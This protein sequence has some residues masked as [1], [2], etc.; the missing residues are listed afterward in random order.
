MLWSHDNEIVYSRVGFLPSRKVFLLCH[1]EKLGRNTFHLYRDTIKLLI[2]LIMFKENKKVLPNKISLSPS[3][4]CVECYV[5]KCKTKLQTYKIKQ[6][7]QPQYSVFAKYRYAC[8]INLL[9]CLTK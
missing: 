4:E 9:I 6:F 7:V 8:H 5:V 3:L 2:C 1:G